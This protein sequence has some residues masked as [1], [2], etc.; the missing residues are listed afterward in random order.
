[1]KNILFFCSDTILGGAE[2][3]ITKLIRELTSRGYRIHLASLE[4]NGNM[5]DLCKE[6]L[7]CFVEIGLYSRNFLR[8][9][10]KYK[11]LLCDYN[12]DIVFNFGLRVE[13][14]S[15]TIAK[16]VNKKIRIISNIR[17]TDDW[18]KPYHT[19]LD[20]ITS[21]SVDL[22]ISNS[23]AGKKVFH[24]REKIPLEK[25]VVIYNFIELPQQKLSSFNISALDERGVK[26]G[27]LANIRPMKGYFDLLKISEKLKTNNVKHQFICGGVD[28]TNGEFEAAIKSGHLED[29]FVLKGY[30]HDKE[31]FFADIDVFILPSY[32]EGMPTCLL[33]AMAYGKPIICSN[34]GGIPELVEDRFNGIVNVPGDIDSFVN[35]IQE[36]LNTGSLGNHLVTNGISVLHQKFEKEK[37]LSR[38]INVIG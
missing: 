38:W 37:C 23:E 20:R 22:W 7:K 33:E 19:W 28:F 1:M 13:L 27:I 32:L 29:D 24:G 5:L 35:S 14:F 15:R 30:V 17:S 26:I 12:I 16:K 25:I 11:V 21:K 10:R 6:D 4:D 3:N 31:A 18:R 2:V 8:S 36:L 9:Y 34:V